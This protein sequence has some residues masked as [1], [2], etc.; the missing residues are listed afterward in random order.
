VL[1]QN[2]IVLVDLR[3]FIMDRTRQGCVISSLSG[4]TIIIIVLA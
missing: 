1:R 2:E 4:S 3:C